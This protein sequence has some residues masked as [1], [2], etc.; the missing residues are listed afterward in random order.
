MPPPLLPLPLSRTPFARADPPT[1]ALLL[2]LLLLAAACSQGDTLPARPSPA[3][4]PAT[5]AAEPAATTGP[6]A[7]PGPAAS[8]SATAGLFASPTPP[9][10]TA[11]AV[12]SADPALL[13]SDSFS[14]SCFRTADDQQRSFGCEDGRFV[15]FGKTPGARWAY[16]QGEFRDA[17]LDVQATLLAG[18]GNVEYGLVFRHAADSER[19][20]GFTVSRYGRYSFF[21]Y[22][23]SRFVDVVRSTESGHVQKEKATNELTVVALDNQFTLFVNGARLRVAQDEQLAQGSVGLFLLNDEP[24]ALVAFDNLRVRRSRHFAPTLVPT[25]GLPAPGGSSPLP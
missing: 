24:N 19:F 18:A 23:R 7:S 16:Y 15:M 17:T 25:P 12:Q 20:Y 3:A 1:L 2:G 14:D 13:L 6:V 9:A 5:A 4:E 10:P 11:T 21:R 22:E 8:P